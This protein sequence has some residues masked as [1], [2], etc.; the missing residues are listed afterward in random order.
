M[1]QIH[2]NHPTNHQ[3][4]WILN[5]I[6][7]YKSHFSWFKALAI[8]LTL[9]RIFCLTMRVHVQGHAA[10]MTSGTTFIMGTS[11]EKC[12]ESME[13]IGKDRKYRE[14]IENIGKI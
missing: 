3:P 11:M 14:N 12:R 1:E 8:V 10:A 9:P 7:H 2:S 5:T 4:T 13:G 6:N